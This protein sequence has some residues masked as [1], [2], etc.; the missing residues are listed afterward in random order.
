MKVDVD[1]NGKP[2][3]VHQ[4]ITKEANWLIEEFMLL[5]NRSVAEFIATGGKMD[6]K[7][8]KDAKTFVYRIHDEPNSEKL[9]SLG[10]FARNFG[11][12]PKFGQGREIAHQLNDLLDS[13][14]EKPEFMPL[15]MLALRAMAKACYS[16]DNIGHY[17]LAFKFYTHFTS[18]I[19]RYPDTMVHRLLSMYLEGASSQNK[20]YYE[21]QCVHASE[22][23]VLAA[24]AERDSTKYKLVEFMQDKIDQE[25]DGHIS[26]LTQWGMYVEIEP[27]KIE[28]MVSLMSIGGDYYDFDEDE[29][30]IR[31][32]YTGKVYRLGDPVRIKV[33]STNLEQRLLDYTLIT[34]EHKSESPSGRSR[35]G[36]SSGRSRT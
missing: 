34:E 1:E 33:K 15:E 19:R 8:R 25:F 35:T 6:G 26:G 31:G 9:Q 10:M 17:G 11:Y 24:N 2:I 29:Y 16:T 4:H 23:E 20:D 30:V 21:E 36:A 22:R 12:Q 13:A 5:A 18:P 7:A 28:G 27:T 14:R 3:G 32:Q